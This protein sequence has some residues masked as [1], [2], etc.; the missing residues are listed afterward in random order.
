VDLAEQ[1]NS[2]FRKHRQFTPGKTTIS[3]TRG[4]GRGFYV[5]THLLEAVPENAFVRDLAKLC[6]DVLWQCPNLDDRGFAPSHLGTG[7]GGF[8]LKRDL[9]PE[10]RTF[11][12][13]EGIR[14][15][16]K[17]WLTDRTGA[18]WPVVCLG[19]TWQ[20]FYVAAAA[21]RY[22]R[23]FGDE[24][25]AD[26]AEAF[27]R[28][29]ARHLLSRQC[30]Q[31]PYYA[32]MDVP[33]LGEAWDPWLFEPAHTATRDGEGCEHDGYY[34]RFFPDAIA[35]AYRRAGATSLLE[36]AREFWHYGSKRG[37]HTKQLSAG[38]D[39]VG[40]FAGH[41]PPKDDTVL[42]ASRMFYEWSHPRRDTEPPARVGDL[43][44]A[45]TEGGRLRVSFTA[46]ADRGGGRVARYQ[47][48]CA[49]LPIVDYDEFDF[50][51][52]RGVKRN[53]WRAA[54]VEG[55]P[56]PSAPGRRESFEISG[57]AGAAP[58]YF[59]VAA[60]DDANNRGPPS[61]PVRALPLRSSAASAVQPVVGSKR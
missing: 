26:F 35:M 38:W 48:K 45:E 25:M 28:F 19:G 15:D 33:T 59:V 49:P 8:D 23:L 17:G 29:A 18:R 10:M 1:K 22:A 55:E 57:G 53:F 5:I 24:D 58:L 41:R 20:H 42:S 34:T 7:F 12:D 40:A 60:Y 6:R 36:R 16:D 46:P 54:N 44:V 47:M 39:A 31:T 43:S 13:Q 2:E 11:M 4:F 37:Y 27:G 30:K 61:E 50:A 51:R 56:A 9:P 32:F 3:D 14:I 52:D 21:E